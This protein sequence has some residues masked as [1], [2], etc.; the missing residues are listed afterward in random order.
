ITANLECDEAHV[1][2]DVGTK[3]IGVE[4]GPKSVANFT[5]APN[6]TLVVDKPCHDL[7]SRN[8]SSTF[9]PRRKAS[10]LGDCCQSATV[11]ASGGA[12]S[13]AETRPGS[14]ARLAA[15]WPLYPML[16]QLLLSLRK[17]R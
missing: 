6:L 7:R 5:V 2:N 12:A 9:P 4:I 16:H 10:S 13:V 8:S 17:I 3:L 1:D 14:K 15:A 11:L